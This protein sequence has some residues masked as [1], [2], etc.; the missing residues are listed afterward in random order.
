MAKKV[1]FCLDY[2]KTQEEKKKHR[3]KKRVP[4]YLVNTEF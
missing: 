1:E 3:N 4:I 2:P